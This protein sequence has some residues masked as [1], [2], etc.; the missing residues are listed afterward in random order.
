MRKVEKVAIRIIAKWLRKGNMARCMRDILPHSGLGNGER[1]EVANIVH[2]VVRFK[3][4]YD[5]IMEIRGMSKTPENYLLLSLKKPEVDAPRSIKYSMSEELAKLTPDE[6]IP[7]INREPDTMLCINLKRISRKG[8]IEIL[9][10]QGYDAREYI[11][12]S[13]LLVNPGARYSS[14]VKDGYAIVQ[15]ASSQIVAKIA[16]SLGTKIMDYCAGSGGKSLAMYSLA[17]DGEFYAYDVNKNKLKNLEKRARLWGM[18]IHIFWDTPRGEF[19]VVLVDAPCSGVGAAAR[20]P[21]AKYQSDFEKFAKVQMEILENAKKNVA[22]GKFL[23]YVVC[24]YTFI[25]TENVVERFL[26]RNKN[27]RIAN[28]RCK[29]SSHLKRAKYGAYLTAGDIFYIS[30]LERVE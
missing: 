10:A 18:P 5:Y 26:K 22:R 23:V 15:D 20:N 9:Q 1:E 12:E 16:A 29:Y 17:D 4:Y 19:D 30:I 14:L 25:E 11:P 2:D 3:K 7:I 8:A 28:V 24:S 13:A 6:F 21:E 27:Y